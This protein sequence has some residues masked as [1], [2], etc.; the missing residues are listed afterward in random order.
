VNNRLICINRGIPRENTSEAEKTREK[1]LLREL[2]Q[3]LLTRRCWRAE[4]R[5]GMKQKQVSG[6]GKMPVQ[7]AG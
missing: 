3:K 2:F 7:R 6:G 4:G 1:S 5:A